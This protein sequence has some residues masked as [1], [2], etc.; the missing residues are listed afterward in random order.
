MNAALISIG[1]ELT[2]G[3]TVDTNSAWLAQRL[4]SLGFRTTQHM[5]VE[6]D[7]AHIA[8]AIRQAV[9]VSDVVIVSGGLGP[10]QDDVTRFALADAMGVETHTDENALEEI[11]ERF[12]QIKRP[13]AESNKIQAQ[14]PIGATMLTNRAGTAPGIV[15][16]IDDTP[17]YVVPGVPREMRRLYKDHLRHALEQLLDEKLDDQQQRNVILTH[18]V[19]TF[20]RGESNVG[21]MLGELMKRGTNPRIGTTVSG[22]LVS[23]RI[24]T[25]ADSIEAADALQL[26]AI[27]QVKQQLGQLVFS[28][29]EESLAYATGQLLREKQKTCA[30]AESCTGGLIGEMLTD[31]PGS[32]EYYLGGWVTY[33]N[34][35]KINQLGVPAEMI[36]EHGAVSEQVASA[37]ARGALKNAN[38]DFAI[39][40]TGVAGP[41]GGTE[42]KPVGTVWIGLARIEDGEIKSK[43]QKFH[44]HGNRETIRLRAA[45]TALNLL[46]ISLTK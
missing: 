43:A 45:L 39:S 29:N 27:E 7:R 19:N 34:D 20:G 38:A 33:A 9:D 14:C 11:A 28:D 21:E 24:Q 4:S 1:D 3:L 5:T 18:K 37:M 6:E 41:D 8:N 46:R 12:R 10:T 23:V 16:K 44:L 42:E 25:Q 2:L 36:E 35:M 32:S 26:E 40:T 30:T 22:G 17:I 15:A 31:I 13:M